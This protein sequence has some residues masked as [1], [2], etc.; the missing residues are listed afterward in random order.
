MYLSLLI[1]ISIRQ[2]LMGGEVM[3][4]LLHS[5]L[6]PQSYGYAMVPHLL[7]QVRQAEKAAEK[8][9]D[10]GEKKRKDRGSVRGRKGSSP[11]DDDG[12]DD[13]ASGDGGLIPA[14]HMGASGAIGPSSSKPAVASGEVSA[15]EVTAAV[16]SGP[17]IDV[18]VKKQKVVVSFGDED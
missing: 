6:R 3:I 13:V 7:C 12:D 9:A 15:S 8:A 11:G 5:M 16:S 10:G 14:A 18:P 1:L 17:P 4:C 2:M